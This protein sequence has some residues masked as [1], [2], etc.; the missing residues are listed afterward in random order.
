MLRVPL[1]R[2][3]TTKLRPEIFEIAWMTAPTSAFTKLRETVS[4][5]SAEPGAMGGAATA[6]G[7]GHGRGEAGGEDAT[8]ET[9]A[10]G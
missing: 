10:A 2:G 6:R 9:L 3:S 8:G 7:H 4:P 5:V 1:T